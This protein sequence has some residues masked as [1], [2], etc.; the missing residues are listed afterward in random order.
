ME[1][2]FTMALLSEWL[3]D[4]VDHLELIVSRVDDII[5]SAFT[6]LEFVS[7]SDRGSI[8]WRSI[9]W[10]TLAELLNPNRYL[11]GVI[12][13]SSWPECESSPCWRRG[14]FHLCRR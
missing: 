7:Y 10:Y 4:D 12:L 1:G 13:F 14:A 6:L 8:I 5:H 3:K 11:S 9:C 2:P